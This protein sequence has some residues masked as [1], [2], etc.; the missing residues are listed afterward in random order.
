MVGLT[1]CVAGEVFRKG[2]MLKAWEN[3]TH[4]VREKKVEGHRLV[5]TG[6]YSL[7]RHPSYAGWFWW[8]IGTQVSVHLYMLNK[9]RTAL[10]E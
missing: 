2:A 1:L 8:S 10:V 9:T 7:C 5:T 3:F 4:L 6:L